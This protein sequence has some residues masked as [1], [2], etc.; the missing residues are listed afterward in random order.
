MNLGNPKVVF[1][2]WLSCR[3]LLN[4]HMPWSQQRINRAAG[5]VFAGLALRLMVAQR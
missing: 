3:S 2:F 5:T 4:R 1:S